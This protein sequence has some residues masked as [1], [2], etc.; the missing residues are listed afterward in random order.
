MTQCDRPTL[1]AVAP[2]I[3]GRRWL[4]DRERFLA[5]ELTRTVDGAGREAIQMELDQVRAELGRQGL[6]RRRWWLFGGRLPQ[7]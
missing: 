3:E 5:D 1:R 7:G 6:S 2:I 4:E